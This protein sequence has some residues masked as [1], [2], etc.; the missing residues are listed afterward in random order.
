MIKVFIIWLVIY[1]ITL[2][3]VGPENDFYIVSN[4]FDKVICYYIYEYSMT[5]F[6]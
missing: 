6:I 2:I 3:K 4:S 1:S 5:N